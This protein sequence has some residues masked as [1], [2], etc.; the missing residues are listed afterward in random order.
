MKYYRLNY[1]KREVGESG[2]YCGTKYSF[3]EACPLCGTGA[4]IEGNLYAKKLPKNKQF[5]KTLDSDFLMSEELYVSALNNDIDLNKLKQ[6]KKRNG[7]FLGY[8]HLKSHIYLPKAKKHQGLIIEDQCGLCKRNGYFNKLILGDLKRNIP[9]L[10]PPVE[11]SYKKEDIEKLE[12]YAVYNT[13][14]CMGLSN[15][16]EYDNYIIR[17]ARPMLVINDNFYK[18]LTEKKVKGLEFTPIYLD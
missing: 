1:V 13:W 16:I 17:Y 10:V 7:D 18:F 9:S 15:K 11:L 12:R 8:Y 3:N 14:E 5:F 2:E 6:V 4:E